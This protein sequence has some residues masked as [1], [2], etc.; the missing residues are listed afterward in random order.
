LSLLL[1]SGCRREDAST[2]ALRRSITRTLSCSKSLVSLSIRFPA[3]GGSIVFGFKTDSGTEVVLSVV[4]PR[5]LRRVP[6]YQVIKLSDTWD[7]DGFELERGSLLEEDLLRLMESCWMTDT[8]DSTH[9]ERMP[10]RAI[11]SWLLKRI[12]ER[13]REWSPCP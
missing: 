10:T 11:L 7:D 1:I 5:A 3:D 13:P 12:K 8:Y 6:N 2:R 4:H 9:S